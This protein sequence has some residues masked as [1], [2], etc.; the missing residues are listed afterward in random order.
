MP[1]RRLNGVAV[2][3]QIRAELMPRVAAFAAAQGRPPAL[4]VVLAGQR[5]ESEIYVRNKIRAVSESVCRADL[6]RL[7]DSASLGETLD[8]VKRLNDNEAID[9]ILVQSPLPTGMGSDAEQ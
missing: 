5:A 4:A 7:D 6:F 3:A 2:A 9:A 1:A 8:L